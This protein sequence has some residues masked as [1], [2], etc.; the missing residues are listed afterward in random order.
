VAGFSPRDKLQVALLLVCL[1]PFVATVFLGFESGNAAVVAVSAGLAIASAGFALAWGAESMQFVVSQVLALAIL[2]LVQVAPEYSVEVVLAYRGATNPAIIHYATAAMTGANRL[3]LGLGWPV[4]F[5]LSWASAR[6]DGR[7]GGVLVLEEHQGVEVFFLGLATVYSFVIV[8]R[9]VIGVGDAFVLLFIFGS[10]L[11]VARR[12]P[13]HGEEKASELEGPSRAVATLKGSKRVA[14]MV[15]FVALG[16]VV[17]VFGSQ[18]F[19]T[20]FLSVMGSLGLNQYLLIQWLTPVLTELPEAITVFYWAAK[21]GKG[22]LALANLISSKLN[23][24]TI[25]VATIPIVYCVASGGF[26]NVVL[27]TQQTEEILLT[28]SQ[29]LFGFVCLMDLK[30]TKFDVG[31]LL[32]LFVVQLVLPEVRPEATAAYLALAAFEAVRERN[33]LELFGSLSRVYGG[34]L[35]RS[36]RARPAPSV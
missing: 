8:A 34:G 28:A 21:T 2:A 23:Q 31:A 19:V 27:T 25:L 36:V 17:I 33:H 1:V 16:A 30:L 14:A 29:S 5:V 6:R 24:W 11:Y 12:L 20:S 15:S 3:L 22:T 35:K 4:V 9:G 7:E 13:P 26:S 10:Y 18:P 32:T